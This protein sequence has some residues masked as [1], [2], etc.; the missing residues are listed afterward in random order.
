MSE[1]PPNLGFPSRLDDHG[2]DGPPIGFAVEATRH[3]GEASNT[4]GSKRPRTSNPEDTNDS[5]YRIEETKEG[6]GDPP[7]LDDVYDDDSVPVSDPQV[8]HKKEVTNYLYDVARIVV[9]P[10]ETTLGFK[11]LTL[12]RERLAR[13]SAP[14]GPEKIELEGLGYARDILQGMHDNVPSVKLLAAL[15]AVSNVLDEK[16]APYNARKLEAEGSLQDDVTRAQMHQENSL[17]FV[18]ITIATFGCGLGVRVR[19]L[20]HYDGCRTQPQNRRRRNCFQVAAAIPPMLVSLGR[21]V[22]RS[23]IVSFLGAFGTVDEKVMACVLDTLCKNGF[24]H[25]DKTKNNEK[26]YWVNDHYYRVS[27]G[28]AYNTGCKEPSIAELT[29]RLGSVKELTPKNYNVGEK[30]RDDFPERNNNTPRKRP[31]EATLSPRACAERDIRKANAA[32]GL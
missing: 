25:C 5:D 27:L 16:E 21:A 3:G 32:M 6:G 10:G 9:G 13:A 14:L 23:E 19:N 12:A 29:R 15:K 4:S 2:P 11:A 31:V 28:L 18:S 24:A 7:G 20:E 22:Y 8:D 1:P 26:R 30:F 17:E